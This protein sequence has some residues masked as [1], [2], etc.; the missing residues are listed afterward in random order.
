MAPPSPR[1]YRLAPRS[2]RIA[3]ALLS[4]LGYRAVE[5]STGAEALAILDNHEDIDLVFSDITMPGGMSGIELAH[6]VHQDYPNLK[7]ILTSGYAVTGI[8]DSN[9]PQSG[10]TVLKKPY[11]IEEL[12]QAVRDILDQE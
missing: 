8:F 11:Q 1:R 12:A 2:L 5:A 3:V 7:V 4:E 9:F 6:H 10:D